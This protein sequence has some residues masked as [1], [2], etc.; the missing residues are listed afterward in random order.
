[1]AVPPFI[2]RDKAIQDCKGMPKHPIDAPFSP[3]RAREVLIHQQKENT[4]LSP[5]GIYYSW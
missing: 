5:V 4:G 1:M 3:Q 2:S